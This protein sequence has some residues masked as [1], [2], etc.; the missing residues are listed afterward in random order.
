[1]M[2]HLGRGGFGGFMG[3]V[4]IQRITRAENARK[5][6]QTLDKGM[7]R[8]DRKMADVTYRWKPLG[9]LAKTIAGWNARHKMPR[10]WRKAQRKAPRK[11][12]GRR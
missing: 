8:A 12:M 9:R 7:Q 1:M 5:P 3:G 6:L 2:L 4:D 11:L 10:S